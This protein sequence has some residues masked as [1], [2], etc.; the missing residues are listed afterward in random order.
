LPF[1]SSRYTGKERDSESGNDYFG[2]RYYASSMGRF[3]S[4]DPSGLM[5]ADPTNPQSLN[6][7]SYAWNNPL[8]NIDPSGME[9]VWDDG[10]YDASDDPQT[11]NAAGCS[12]QGG[13]YIDPSMFES[14]EGNQAGSWSGQASSSIASDWLTPS[15]VVNG[16]PGGIPGIMSDISGGISNWVHGQVCDAYGGLLG[17]ASSKNLNSTVGL[18]AGGNGGVGFILGVSASAGAQFVADPKGNVGVAFSVGGNPGY[19]VFGVGVMG[20]VQASV[21][22][23]KTISDLRGGSVDAGASVGAGPAVSLD[24]SAAMDGSSF[25]GTVTVG[26]GVGTKG[27]ALGV[28]Y[29]WVPSALSTNCH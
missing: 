28:D 23:A 18:G 29:T 25:T 1:C 14:V 22:T 24:G 26:P 7:Y 6:L 27:S 4:P 15:A 13:T 8:R 10:S 11:G 9:C 19:G 2:A 17:L 3:L 12:G 20:G 16:G 21:S 5:Y